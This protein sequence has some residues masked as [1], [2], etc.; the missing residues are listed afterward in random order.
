[1]H[2]RFRDERGDH[3]LEARRHED[4]CLVTPAGAADSTPVATT[5]DGAWLVTLADGSR[6]RAWVVRQGDERLVFCRGRLHRLRR[7][8]AV[9]DDQAAGD[10]ADGP[11]LHA[12]MPGKVVRL[13]VGVG[14][15]VTAGQPL[16]IME[17]M[18]METELTAPCV[19][20]VARVVAGEGQ[21]VAQ[22]ELLVAL[23][24]AAADGPLAGR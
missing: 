13:L 9:H 14:Q 21:V 4:G 19:G 10:G 16:V 20:V 1:M 18:K 7:P 8:D 5:A 12:R 15:T 22:G 17:S 2:L 23:T 3:D 6:H 24:P 11:D